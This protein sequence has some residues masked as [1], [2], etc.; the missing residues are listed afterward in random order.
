MATLKTYDD[1]VQDVAAYLQSRVEAAKRAGVYSWNILVDPGV[2][3]AKSGE[4]NLEV[5]RRL[6][7]LKQTCDGLP[8]L[9]GAS[10][11]GFIG[12]ICGRAEPKD[13]AW[14]TAATCCAAI[15]GGA[16][17][18]RVHDVPAM[19]DVAKMADAIWRAPSP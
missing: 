19:V 5:L 10:R 11:K 17:V 3:F 7:E 8:V 9:V 16:D 15:A 1:V 18:L 12:Q 4:L 13:R 2:G 14:G 6:R